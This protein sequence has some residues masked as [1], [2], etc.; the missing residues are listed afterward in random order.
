MHDRGLLLVGPVDR[1]LV[2]QVHKHI[3]DVAECVEV[4]K[5][6]LVTDLTKDHVLCPVDIVLDHTVV[7]VGPDASEFRDWDLVLSVEVRAVKE[8]V[9]EG[10]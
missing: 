1:F 7:V 2:W 6:L 9:L 5:T 3:D 10:D 4:N 8:S